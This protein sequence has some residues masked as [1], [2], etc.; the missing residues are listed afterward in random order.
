ME[1]YPSLQADD[2][3]MHIRLL[4]LQPC[5]LDADFND[6]LPVPAL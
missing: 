3:T 5:I 1:L 2:E 4:D 6:K